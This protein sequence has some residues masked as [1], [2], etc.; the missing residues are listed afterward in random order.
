[1]KRNT[2]VQVLALLVTLVVA[3]LAACAVAPV[4]ESADRPLTRAEFAEVLRTGAQLEAT[5]GVSPDIAAVDLATEADC[6]APTIYGYNRVLEDEAWL[7][8]NFGDAVQ[9]HCAEPHEDADYVFR[10]TELEA[11]CGPAVL[12]GI[13]Q[14]EFGHPLSN[15]AVI[16]GW[17]G[18]EPLPAYDPP[19]SRYVWPP[20]PDETIAR[21]IV[22]WTS[23]VGDVG[24]GL[25]SGDYYWPETSSGVSWMYIADYDGP[26]D[27]LTGLGMLAGTEHCALR[28]KWL[29][30]PKENVN[31]VTPTPP[32]TP[33]PGP[34]TPTVTPEV[35]AGLIEVEGI[36]LKLA[37]PAP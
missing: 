13:V 5:P 3:L 29:R 16:R 25:G 30:I 14:D 27:L 33:T 19:A 28:G 12:I 37:T 6:P 10:L 36:Y 35:P 22:G 18:A 21:G 9:W 20:P 15:R 1:M 7:R 26:S 31:P 34:G 8:A 24:F 32:P 2:R 23:A 17:P 4:Q 11:A